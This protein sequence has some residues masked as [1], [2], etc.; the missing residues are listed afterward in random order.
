MANK[1]Q[2]LWKFVWKEQCRQHGS[3]FLPH[4]E[5]VKLRR[6]FDYF[7]DKFVKVSGATME[8]NN[9]KFLIKCLFC[10]NE[11]QETFQTTMER[12]QGYSNYTV[13]ETG[14]IEIKCI[15]CGTFMSTDYEKRN[16]GSNKKD[17]FEM[18]CP[19]CNSTNTDFDCGDVDCEDDQEITCNDCKHNYIYDKKYV[20][21]GLDE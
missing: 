10:G 8:N 1:K 9:E 14:F 20:Y 5:F 16:L 18:I 4:E 12:D 15:K 3:P 11:D 19:K 17:S 21:G 13:E 7:W 6:R 2:M